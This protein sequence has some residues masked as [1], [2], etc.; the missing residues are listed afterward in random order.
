MKKNSSLSYQ[1]TWQ[2]VC[3][4]RLQFDSEFC[5]GK[6]P[7][8]FCFDL[9][10]DVVYGLNISFAVCRDIENGN[11]FSLAANYSQ[12]VICDDL[13]IRIN[14]FLYGSIYLIVEGV[15]AVNRVRVYGN[16][17]IN[18]LN[19]T[20]F[21]PLTYFV[22]S[23]CR[24]SIG[25]LNVQAYNQL[26]TVLMNDYIMNALDLP[27]IHCNFF[28][29]IYQVARGSLADNGVHRLPEHV[30]AGVYDKQ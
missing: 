1:E 3:K 17:A 23:I 22:Y 25:Y 4:D 21:N 7:L 30:N 10:L 14:N 13:L 24:Q 29:C 18:F 9:S 8:Q 28:N 2:S 20:V 15:I 16:V 11:K 27:Y 26:T 5:T 6:F 19:Y 12:I